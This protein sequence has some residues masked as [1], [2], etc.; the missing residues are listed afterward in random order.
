MGRNVT[1]RP[2]T[3]HVATLNRIIAQL[4]IDETKTPAQRKRVTKLITQAM[5]ELQKL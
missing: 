1:P 2:T 3:E 4:E 5:Q